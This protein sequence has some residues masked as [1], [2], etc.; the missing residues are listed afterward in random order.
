[1]SRLTEGLTQLNTLIFPQSVNAEVTQQRQKLA[2]LLNAIAQ[3]KQKSSFSQPLQGENYMLFWHKFIVRKNERGLLFKNGDFQK[4]L[5]PGT[6][7]YFDLLHTITLQVF[8]LSTPEFKH[9]L[10]DFLLQT[11]PE[12]MANFFTVVELGTQQI[13][14]VYKNGHLVEILSPSTRTLY[15]KGFVAITVETVDISSDFTIPA[16]K[17]HAL[18]HTQLPPLQQQVKTA[19][20]Y[21]EVP[22]HHCGLLSVDERYEQILTSGLHA[23]WQFNRKLNVEIHDLA[24]P[25]LKHRLANFRLADYPPEI[26][27]HFTQVELDAHQ[28]ALIYKNGT[29]TNMLAPSTR[30][31][32]W[33]GIIDVAIETIDIS[34]NFA[35]PADKFDALLH[36]QLPALQ[37]QLKSA[38][39]YQE[40][41]ENYLGLLF[42]DKQCVRA[43][44]AGLHAY[45]NFNR[46]INVEIYDLS[47]PQF[48][49]DLANFRL[50]DY[51]AE[52]ASYF[53][54]IELNA[55][56]VAL[57]YENS[58][59]SHILPP[60]TRA[61]Y[62]KGKIEI[63]AEF[64][65]I[66]ENFVV[67]PDKA[68]ILVHTQNDRLKTMVT[69]A[70]YYN[71]V[72][73]HRVGL[74]YVEGQYVTLLKSGL[75]TYWKFN[76][77]IAIKTVDTRLQE[78]E[79]S[80]QEI[81]TKDKVGL[82]INLSAI[83]VI[84]DVLK[85]VAALVEPTDYLYKELQFGLRA[86]VG[87]RTLDEL[88][89]NKTVIDEVVFAH[90][91]K[92]VND[93]GIHL[94]SVGVK[95]IILPGEMRTI[96][97][98][99]V[100]AEKT[101]QANIIRR[102]EETAATRSLLNTAKVMEDNPTALR[103]KELETLEKV[104]EK[105]GSISVYGG[106]E[107]LLK[108]LVKIRQ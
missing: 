3:Q 68:N 2:A 96:L 63:T 86:A 34:S 71:E 25:E 31:T 62:W 38:I 92:K 76:R 74:L 8:D 28:V 47:K 1:M 21:Q 60:S 107:G 56:Q 88:L 55:Q 46:K 16:D 69:S 30:A 81:L 10:T 22:E 79:V 51:P 61:T 84:K 48:N 41:P 97:S 6:Y 94:Q 65:D 33:K 90:V 45:W 20:Y 49:H 50:A 4:F 27:R 37:Q 14:L 80:G 87:T 85:M 5:A 43:L 53:T 42:V 104:T 40:I 19:V 103:L 66:S 7:H 17:I 32:Y 105:I 26:A 29:L 52:I 93:F 64:I 82:R 89:E 99:V 18:L 39:Y 78:M 44:T 98:R 95:D 108:E 23:Y 101:A 15:W 11:Y 13:G 12:D 67:V 59:L 9:P 75:H 106:L 24:T 57:I 77:D 36:T 102:R 70:I 72:P 73:E 54:Q 58:I 83:Y 35:I 100:E 91:Q